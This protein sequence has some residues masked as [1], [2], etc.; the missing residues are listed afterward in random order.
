MNEPL[1]S[2]IQQLNSVKRTSKRGVEYWVARDIQTILG[3]VEWVKF[4]KV[5]QR[6]IKACESVGMVHEHHFAQTGKM[7]MIGSGAQRER[8][9]Y[10]LDRYAC[11]LIA[12]N[13]DASKPEVG[14]AQTYFAVQ[15]RRQEIHDQLSYEEKRLQLRD[16]VKGAN[17]RLSDTAKTAGVQ[18]F[19]IFH[20]AGY[21]GLY[22]MGIPGLKKKKGISPKE[23]LLDRMGR[24]ELAANEF[25][26]TQTQ[27]KLIRDN[28]HG[29]VAAT[30]T[31][32]RVGQEV[33]NTI[34]KLGGT[35]PEELPIEAPITKLISKRRKEIK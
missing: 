7:V 26:I 30:E 15:T 13:G 22:E 12:M 28:I 18:R 21:H 4:E 8:G 25:R 6:A 2:V 19:N 35:M 33:R 24:T 34:K 5:I 31:H 17:K 16:R 1:D 10:F 27:D 3:Y 9:D 14:I 29:E 11:Y 32:R 23:D 20:A